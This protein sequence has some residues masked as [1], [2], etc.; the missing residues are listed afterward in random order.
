MN[1]LPKKDLVRSTLAIVLIG[2]LLAACFWIVR[3]FLPALIWASMIV[4]ATWPL[5]IIVEKRVMGRRPAVMVMMG[6]L[7]L[8]FVIPFIL[9]VGTIVD[10]AS[11]ITTL[12][13]QLT[14]IGI[15]AP[16]EW[17]AQIPLVGNSA[18]EFW[19][20]VA[21][22]KPEEFSERLTPYISKMTSWLVT[23]PIG[24]G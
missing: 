11:Q 19:Q 17:V 9:A 3:P 5:L 15:P 4:I 1:S 13:K 16:P 21:E 12:G 7:L 23:L 2:A 10:N 20:E 14:S 22:T 18:S 24:P 6:L 8:V